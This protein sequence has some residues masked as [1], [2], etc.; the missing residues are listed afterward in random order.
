MSKGDVIVHDDALPRVFWKLGWIQEVLSSRD[1][2]PRA[3]LVRVASR[4]RQHILLRSPLQLF[5]PLEI[6]KAE[7]PE[8]GCEDAPASIPDVRISAPVE[9]HDA[10]TLKEP[11]RRPM[12]AAANEKMRAWTQE[13]WD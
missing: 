9:E 11:E 7:M 5:Y 2:H 8:T 6:H 1:G 12:C 13:L 10:P 3:A 4:D